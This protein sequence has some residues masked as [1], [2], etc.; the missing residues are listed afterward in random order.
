MCGIIGIIGK[1]PVTPLLVEALKRVG[2]ELT[3][4]KLIQT[5]EGFYEFQTGLM[6]P[7]TYGP[8]RRIGALG[9]YVVL[10]D[11]KQKNFKPVSGWVG[12]EK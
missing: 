10:V 9:A 5:L 1:A 3:R 6:P 7:L 12:I 11:L 8:N 4:E 2:K